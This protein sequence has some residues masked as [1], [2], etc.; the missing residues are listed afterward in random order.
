MTRSGTFVTLGLLGALAAPATSEAAR[1][2]VDIGATPTNLTGWNNLIVNNPNQTPSIANAV[3]SDGNPTTIGVAITNAFADDNPNGT[4]SPTGDAA[5]L[6]STATQDSAFVNLGPTNVIDTLGQVTVS[7]LVEGRSYSFGFFASRMNPNIN[8]TVNRE[9]DFTIG[10]V[11]VTLNADDN[12]SDFVWIHD[13]IADATGSLVIDVTKTPGGGQFGYLG[14]LFIDG[15]FSV[16]EPATLG[17]LGLGGLFALR[18][19]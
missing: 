5:D 7:G 16:P 4:T 1:I 9:T 3:D 12:T 6:P 11:T 19:R 18:R 2:Q 15:D 8:D 17:L 13:V 10:G 14:V